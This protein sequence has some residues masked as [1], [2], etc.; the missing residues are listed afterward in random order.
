M[1]KL[2]WRRD[3]DLRQFFVVARSLAGL[4]GALR[5]RAGVFLGRQYSVVKVRV[6]FG[7]AHPTGTSRDRYSLVHWELAWCTA[8]SGGSCTAA[9]QQCNCWGNNPGDSQR[10]YSFL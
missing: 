4:G 10:A 8:S 9:P 6:S 1:C 3:F 5:R 7:F 2:C